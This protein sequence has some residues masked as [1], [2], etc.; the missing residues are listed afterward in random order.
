MPAVEK[1]ASRNLWGYQDALSEVDRPIFVVG[2]PRSGTTL[3][4]NSFAVRPDLAWF[5]HHLNWMPRWPS[6]TVLARLANRFPATR[7]SIARS[8][9]EQHWLEKL[10]IGPAEAYPVWRRHLGDRFLY[11]TLTNVR[12]TE[13]ERDDI[14]DLFRKLLRY[15]NK[16][17][18]ATKITGPGRIGFLSS[19]FPDAHF[20]HV[21]RDGRA[22]VRSLRQ[23]EFWRGTWREREVAW[24]NALSSEELE[25]WRGSGSSPLV[26]AALEWRALVRDTRRDGEQLVPDRYAEVRYED[27]IADP[28]VAIDELARFCGLPPAAEPHEYISGRVAVRDMNRQWA[29]EF[30][31]EELKLLEEVIG[32]DLAALGYNGVDDGRHP[33]VRRPFTS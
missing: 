6:V 7:K 3:I 13:A 21:I 10:R 9:R 5:T 8:D 12:P 22:V 23:V 11:E 20:I 27:F 4:F 25:R 33:V 31:G 2:V 19:I 18:F 29:D 16:P 28:Y 30:S 17:R 32:A 15:Q 14:R 24:R 26:L 1:T